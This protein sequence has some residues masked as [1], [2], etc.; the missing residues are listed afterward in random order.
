VDDVLFLQPEPFVGW[1]LAPDFSFDWA[2][3]N[4]YCVEFSVPVRTNGFGFRDRPWSRDRTPGV[5]RIAVLG[6]SFV[7]AIQVPQELTATRLLE[8]SLRRR[9]PDRR[10]ETMNFGVSNYSF[11]QYLMVYEAFVR[12]F[13][14]DYVVVLAAYLQF[15]RTTQRALSSVLQDFYALEIRPSFSLDSAG[16]VVAMPP[17]QHEAYARRVEE[18]IARDYGP[19]RSRPV[20]ALPSPLYLSTWLLSTGISAASRLPYW[21]PSFGAPEF[22]DVDL[23]HEILRALHQQ[24]REDGGVLLF[25]DAFQYLE[26][27][28]VPRGSG[29]LAGG[30][31]SFVH[32]LGARYLNVSPAMSQVPR[33][34]RF[35]CDMH[36]SP[37]E[38]RRLADALAAW[39][40]DELRRGAPPPAD[41]DK[42]G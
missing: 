4:P 8:E 40:F 1:T 5:T 23:N 12:Q 36:F 24:V 18:L 38:H 9:F 29:R 30:N 35:R 33:A 14:P 13:K 34:E 31:E 22:T 17:R 7:E 28:G 6:D 10:F 21:R 16:R 3:R 27:F 39:F 26:Q 11:G 25:L 20:F 19:D 41:V 42:S 32:E 37:A 2:G 15:N